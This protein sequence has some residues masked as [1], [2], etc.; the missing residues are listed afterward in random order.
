MK[1]SKSLSTN[2]L[3]NYNR[4]LFVSTSLIERAEPTVIICTVKHFGTFN[5]FKLAFDSY[6][7]GICWS[8]LSHQLLSFTF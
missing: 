3:D 1:E 5:V 8:E 6:T 4:Q 2:L 7:K